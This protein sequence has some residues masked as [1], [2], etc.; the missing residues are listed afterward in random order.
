MNKQIIPLLLGALFMTG[1]LM[2]IEE[3]EYSVVKKTDVYDI[4]QYKAV[5]AIETE[6]EADFEDAGNRAFRRLFNYI[7]GD[8]QSQSKISMTAPVTQSAASEK[9][10]MTAPVTQSERDGKYVVRFVLPAEYT[11]ET[12]PSPN[13]PTVAVTLLPAR[14]F[15]VYTYSG[16]WSRSGYDEALAKLKQALAKDA[17]EYVNEPIWARYNSPFSLWFLRRNEVWL[18]IK[19]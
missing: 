17:V 1:E 10:A 8:N 7:D 4:R 3:P 19:R 11:L 9:I 18:P 16:F 14:S 12:A 13:D 15:A 2:A 5:V 6:V